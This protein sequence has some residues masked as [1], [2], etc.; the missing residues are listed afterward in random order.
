M[1]TD[2]ENDMEE[3][4]CALKEDTIVEWT[5]TSGGDSYGTRLL[6]DIELMP[7]NELLYGVQKGEHLDGSF[8][9]SNHNGRVAAGLDA[10]KFNWG[11]I[12]IP[13]PPQSS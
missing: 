9:R 11:S 6:K 10:R 5:F 1:A 12:P 2:S 4:K 8:Y 13:T 3:E 7:K